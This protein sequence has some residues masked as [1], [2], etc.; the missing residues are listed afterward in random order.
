MMT[1]REMEL[2]NRIL[3]L[4]G[5]IAETRGALVEMERD[6]RQCEAEMREHAHALPVAVRVEVEGELVSG[7]V[8]GRPRPLPQTAV[9]GWLPRGA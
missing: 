3:N 4:R 5:V 2:H 7:E 6:L 8:F 1:K 9:R